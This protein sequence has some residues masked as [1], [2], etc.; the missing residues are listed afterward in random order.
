MRW[1]ILFCS[2]V[3]AGCGHIPAKPNW[4]VAPNIGTCPELVDAIPSEKF[5]ELLKTVTTN[6][7]KYHECKARVDAWQKWYDDQQKIYKDSK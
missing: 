5:S 6:Y 2:L 1:E 3:L 4:P 7:G